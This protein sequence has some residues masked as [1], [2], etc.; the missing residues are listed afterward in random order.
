[1]SSAVDCRDQLF[2]R[3]DSIQDEKIVSEIISA[4]TVTEERVSRQ[5]QQ[6]QVQ[7]QQLTIGN[8]GNVIQQQ[9]QQSPKTTINLP[10][11]EIPTF[12]GDKLKWSEFWDTFETTIDRNDSLSGIEKLKYL[13]SKLTGEAKHAVSG[14]ILSNDNH[15]VVVTLMKER[16]GEV[17]TVIN[18]HYTELINLTPANNNPRSLRS[19]FDQIER[20]VRSLQALKQDI[21]QDVFVSIITK[22]PKDVLI[23]LEIQKGAKTK[24]TVTKLREL[25]NNYIAERERAD[26]QSYSGLGETKYSLPRQPMGTTET[27]ISGTRMSPRSNNRR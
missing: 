12:N 23:Q 16:F 24:W 3:Q 5:E 26:Q 25:F 1:M 21:D 17:Q 7:M 13:N 18:A 8:K 19:L 11:L 27:L 10:K 22:I 14:I 15:Q 2:A 20:N 9:R 6:L 4:V